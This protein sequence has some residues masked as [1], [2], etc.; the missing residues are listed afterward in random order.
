[1]S[2]NG[3]ENPKKSH[4]LLFFAVLG[5][6]L[7]GL[8]YKSFVPG[9]YLFFNDTPLGQSQAAA[10]QFPGAFVGRWIDL[11]WLGIEIPSAA[12][13]ISTMIASVTSTPGYYKFFIPLTLLI[14]GLSA[15]LFFRQL[16]F[17]PMVCLVGGLAAGLNMQFLSIGCWG[18]GTWTLASASMFLGLA[19]MVSP[20]IKQG[21]LRAVLAGLGIGMAVCE[22]YDVG[23]ILSIYAGIFVLF[24]VFVNTESSVVKRV[25]KSVWIGGLVVVFALLAAIHAVSSLWATQIHGIVGTSQDAQTRAAAWDTI[26]SGSL[27]KKETLSLFIPGVFGYRMDTFIRNDEYSSVYWGCLN[28]YPL[29]EKLTSYDAE[30]RRQTFKAIGG[31]PKDEELIGSR[32]PEVWG[33]V[34]MEV[35]QTPPLN[36]L[37]RRHT[38]NGNYAGV[39]VAVLAVFGIASSL[40]G[41]GSALS[42]NERLAVWFWFFVAVTSLI[43][44][45]GR[46]GFLYQ[47]FYKLPYVSNI[48]GPYKFLYPFQ[49]A[50]IILAGYGLETLYRHYIKPNTTATEILPLQI[51]IWWSKAVGFEKKWGWGVVIGLGVAF[52]ATF[53]VMTGQKDLVFYLKL[54]GFEEHMAAGI[55]GFCFEQ[56]VWFVALLTA[57]VAIVLGI[58]SGVWNGNRAKWAWI[59]LS[60][61]MIIDLGHAAYRWPFYYDFTERYM[62]NPVIEFLKDKPYEHRFTAYSDPAGR[63]PLAGSSQA[64]GAYYDMLQNQI[65]FLNIQSLDIIQMPRMPEFDAAYLGA[66]RPKS[67]TDISP[68]IR[69]WQLTNTRYMLADGRLARYPGFEARLLYNAV[70]KP[71]LTSVRG[72]EDFTYEQTTNG[73]VAVLELTNV[74]PR[75]KLFSNWKIATTNESETLAE[76]ASPGFDYSKTVIVAANTPVKAASQDPSPDAGDVTITSYKPKHITLKASAK[77]DAVLLFN[78]HTDPKWRTWVDG[79]PVETLRCNYI[80]RGVFLPKGEHEIVMRYQPSLTTLYICVATWVFGLAALAMVCV[81]NVRRGKEQEQSK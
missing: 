13:D 60:A 49:V 66:F 31:N 38:G 62:T 40:R 80:M 76:L 65:P 35:L 73:P 11:S 26:T 23:A 1:M 33:K 63:S 27:P 18:L 51:K 50:W 20:A 53:L 78:D 17:S 6:V 29:V 54:H 48:R 43:F 81:A 7:A 58:M 47:F 24:H 10:Y 28:E 22:G 21:W 74:L 70:P 77:T 55:A 16:R 25:A 46:H 8:F 4:F 12:P 64:S 36:Q 42:R 57:A 52:L 68:C 34:A 39:L 44:A 69:M 30:V 37:Q 72:W 32:D 67:Q 9:Q 5:I 14:V 59:F 79:K 56:M 61:L 75:A 19:A 45:F 41:K 3:S 71:G 2:Q 15:W